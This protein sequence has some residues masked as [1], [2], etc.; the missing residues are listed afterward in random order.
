MEDL[1]KCIPRGVQHVH[2]PKGDVTS[3]LVILHARQ[4][5]WRSACQ[6]GVGRLLDLLAGS[7]MPL[8]HQAR[9]FNGEQIHAAATFAATCAGAG[10]AHLCPIEVGHCLKPGV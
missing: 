2:D 1:L 4:Q 5:A 10:T 6:Q 9:V 8:T 3:R 7:L